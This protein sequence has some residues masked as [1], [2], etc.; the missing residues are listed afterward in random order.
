[1]GNRARTSVLASLT[2][3]SVRRKENAQIGEEEIK[4]SLFAD[5]RTVYIQSQQNPPKKLLKLVSDFIK[6]T[7]YKINNCISIYYQLP[8]LKIQYYLCS[9]K[10]IYI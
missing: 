8:K 9:F 7:G 6:V 2:Q 5:G 10:K 3:H 4:L 1:M